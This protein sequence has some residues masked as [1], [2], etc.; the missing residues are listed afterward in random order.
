MD[1]DFAFLADSATVAEVGKLDIRGAGIDTLSASDVPFEHASLTLVARIVVDMSE[2]GKIHRL[3][4]IL[5][6]PD[7]D[8]IA[9]VSQDTDP[10]QALANADRRPSVGFLMTMSNLRFPSFGCYELQLLWDDR[11]LHRMPLFVEPQP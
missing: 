2:I 3:V 11:E 5:R 10:V 6:D 1:L 9:R 4:V 7:R 8:E